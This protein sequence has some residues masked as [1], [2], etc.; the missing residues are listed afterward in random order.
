MGD[1]NMERIRFEVEME[2]NKGSIHVYN[3]H[4]RH[5][6][7]AKYL[8]KDRGKNMKLLQIE[9][10][11]EWQRRGIGSLLVVMLKEIARQVG[12]KTI[13]GYAINTSYSFWNKM[14]FENTHINQ[15]EC[16]I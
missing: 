13:W 2:K 16:V 14:G 10:I 11:P 7:F 3:I 4:D 12:C 1:K 15:V 6:G 8:I 9:I 5:I